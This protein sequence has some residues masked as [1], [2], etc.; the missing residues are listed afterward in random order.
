[1][2]PADVL[3]RSDVPIELFDQ[4][5]AG[6]FVT[7]ALGD[8]L[9]VNRTAADMLGYLEEELVGKNIAAVT[10]P[11]DV[12]RR[13]S[14]GAFSPGQTLGARLRLLHKDGQYRVTDGKEQVLEDGR[15]L[16]VVSEVTALATAQR[17]LNEN[18][19]QLR[20]V[21]NLLPALIA[22]VD[23]DARYVWG[24]ESYRRWYGHPPEWIRGRHA[25][26]VLGPAAW[27]L[28]RPYVE[29]AVAGEE[30]TFHHR[31]VYKN[32]PARDI[33]ASYVPHLDARGRVRGFVGLV[34]DITDDKRAE[35]ALRRSEHMLEQSQSTAHVGS[36]E[37]S[38]EDGE[39][40]ESASLRW[41][42]EMYRIFGLEPVGVEVTRPM[43]FGYVHPDDR[44]ALRARSNAGLERGEPFEKEYRIVRPDGAVRTIQSWNRFEYDAG[45][46]AIRVLGTC[47]D[48]TDRKQAEQEVRQA[49]EDLQ[50]VMDSTA[51]IIARCDRE[52]RIVWTN[53]SNA[54]RVGKTPAE[55]VGR[56]LREI[57]GEAAYLALEKSIDRVLT[58]ETVE[59]ETE[60][61]YHA[62]GPRWVHIV[63]SPTF[64]AAG[65]PDGWVS[66]LTDNTH[67]RELER[68]LRLSEERYRSLIGAITSVVWT[69]DAEGRFVEPQPAWEAYTGQS[70]RDHRD[71]GWTSAV[72][73]D[74]RVRV[75]GLRTGAASTGASYRLACRVWH[76][77]SAG[78]RFC[79]TSA[80]AIRN[81]DGAIREWIGTL[82]DVHERERALFELREADRRKDEFLAMLSHELRNPL[83]PILNAVEV[84]DRA[85]HGQEELAARFRA[86]IARQVQHMKRLL[87]DLLDV[88][89]VSQGKI[90]LR[91]ERL[92]LGALL[93]QAVEVSRPMIVEKR[94]ELSVTLAPGPLPLEADP[95]RLVQVFGNLVN[96]AAKYTDSGGHIALTVAAENGEAVVRVRDD[97]MGMSPELLAQAFDLFVQ[98][99]RS[100]D[101]AQGGLGIGVTM[102]RTLVKMHGGSVRAFSDGPGRGS[103]FVV[104]LP[105]ALQAE[106]PPAG[107]AAPTIK[108]P[109]R[110]LRV[111]LVDDNVDAANA[112]G[113]LLEL[114][115]HEVTVAYDGPGALAAAA[116]VAPE[117][118]LLDLGLPGMDGYAVAVRLRDAGHERATL[119][120]LTG[121]GQDEHMRRSREAGFDHHLVKPLDFAALEQITVELRAGTAKS[122]RRSD[123][124]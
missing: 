18:A 2:Q 108:A 122:A 51:A 47:Q 123:G 40:R 41:S 26:E 77:P 8:V 13:A 89:R 105:L 102:A 44:D 56:P 84:L 91:K 14:L 64:D 70:W 119:V 60:V 66:V 120:A 21:A 31:L 9:A 113:H 43:F 55:I 35:L 107:G 97:G 15:I 81:L 67:R 42:S 36:W 116:A 38:L 48:I 93:L 92:E 103:E 5:A 39:D 25:S 45:G 23:T 98:E 22:Y 27:E 112:V 86:I 80:V 49:R 34:N 52:R 87:D 109:S 11:D 6:I 121:Y 110:A 28:V 69:A 117:L 3:L 19:E 115:G 53:K 74:D 104:R 7:D 76:A 88:S 57:E 118:V 61:P 82:V 24:N 124:G 59:L 62:L 101:R 114:L 50:V 106:G 72:H 95:T 20:F 32:G 111:L 90:Q 33:R 16:T 10:H 71:R 1:V 63:Y 78:Y 94:Q 17:A 73:E 4:C 46:K 29:R 54:A 96:N 65:K 12:A 30:V 58:G 37:L 75:E 79:E 68:A 100:L 85:G 99:T 83:A